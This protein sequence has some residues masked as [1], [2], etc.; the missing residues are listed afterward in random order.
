MPAATDFSVDPA[1]C[2]RCGECAADCVTGAIDPPAGG[3]P[4]ALARPDDCI[5]CQHCLAVCPAAA[6][7][8]FGKRPADSP[9]VRDLPAAD[10]MKRLMAG[11]RSI[12]RFHDEDLPRAALEDLVDAAAHAPTGVNKRNMRFT[13]L[14]DR[15]TTRA[16]RTALYERIAD[17]LADPARKPHPADEA[18]A[19]LA[20]D[21]RATG[22]DDIFRHAPHLVLATCGADTRC[23]E[24]DPV[25]AL[26]HLDLYAQTLGVGTVWA[27]FVVTALA[28]IPSRD[29]LR[30]V[31]VP[32][33]QRM[34]YALLLGRPIPQY[35]RGAQRSPAAVHFHSGPPAPP[36][37]DRDG[38]NCA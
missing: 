19:E 34:G 15:R 33:G 3:R 38:G 20:R 5:G 26:A 29:L 11:R 23:P 22:R 37:A 10:A 12:R 31:G 9:P 2:V 36:R 14:A 27:G 4:P 30:G 35:P 24:A 13:V 8:I 28:A 25:I 21:W 32:R 6:L 17:A 16:F 7:S 18:L 1:L